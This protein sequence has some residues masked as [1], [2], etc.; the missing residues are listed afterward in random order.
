MRVYRAANAG[1]SEDRAEQLLTEIAHRP[2]AEMLDELAAALA[3]AE[4]AGHGDGQQRT[5][6]APIHR[7][8]SDRGGR[9]S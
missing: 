4:P 6:G 3:R 7:G 1:L 2:R 5:G 8:R 9:A